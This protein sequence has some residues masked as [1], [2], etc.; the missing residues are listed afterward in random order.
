MP[1]TASAV[2]PPLPPPES[3]ETIDRTAKRVLRAYA[4]PGHPAAF[5][6]PGAIARQLNLPRDEVV[7]ALEREDSYTVHREYKKPAQFN[8]YFIRRRRRLVQADLIQIDA[9]YR[10][11][12]GIR[13]LLLLIDVFTR[14]VWVVPLKKKS[15]E[16]V[17]DALRDWLDHDVKGDEPEVFSSDAGVEFFNAPVRRLFRERNI[18]QQLAKGKAKAA[19]A[20]R[21][22]KTIQVLIYKYLTHGRTKKYIDALPLLVDTYNK[23]GHRSLDYMS[24]DEADRPESEARVQRI[25]EARF[26][27]VKRK[28]P[29]Y[30]VGDIVRLKLESPGGRRLWYGNRAY[31]KQFS[32][33]LYKI[34]EVNTRLPIPLYFIRSWSKDVPG[35]R[36]YYAGELQPVRGEL[37]KVERIV[38]W[39]GEAP[40]R[41]ALVKWTNFDAGHNR[42]IPEGDIRL[43]N[44]ENARADAA[45]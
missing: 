39:R 10:Q 41:Q 22:N 23:R 34:A 20:E 28:K 24:P 29:E 16:V 30:R 25:T 1:A 7:R 21:A 37:F 9:L 26:E 32:D 14:K 8:P 44:H 43:A 13:Y 42:W 2:R 38:R 4:R 11:N 33:E 35:K 15:A 18:D 6:A 5:S 45:V 36:G 17:R 31:A 12:G 40:N 19:Y 27:K 3:P